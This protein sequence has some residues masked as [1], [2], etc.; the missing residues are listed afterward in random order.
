MFG[1]STLFGGVRGLRKPQKHP[2]QLAYKGTLSL[3]EGTTLHYPFECDSKIRII[4]ET[5]KKGRT[6]SV[7]F[8]KV[9]YRHIK[10]EGQKFVPPFLVKRASLSLTKT[11]CLTTLRI[12]YKSYGKISINEKD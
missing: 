9:R 10:K 1:I 6:Y 8:D 7:T 5:T 3:H 11:L 2:F 12:V 4:L